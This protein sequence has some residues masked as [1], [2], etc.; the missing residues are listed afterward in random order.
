MEQQKYDFD[1]VVRGCITI[2][3]LVGLYFV[4][5]RLSGVLVPF[6][7][8]WLIAYMLNPLCEFYQYKCRMKVRGLAVAAT[9][10]TAL[11]A[12]A[13]FVLM[14]IP[15]M[16]NEMHHLSDYLS[17]YLTDFRFSDYVPEEMQKRLRDA[18]VD[19]DLI[20]LVQSDGFLSVLQTSAPKLWA[21]LSGGVSA[22]SGL[23]VSFICV[24]YIIFI[25]LD[26]DV[27]AD[28]WV[29]MIPK[30]YRAHAEMLMT[31]LSGGMNSYFRGQ[32]KVASIV[33]ILFAIGFEIIGLPLG[34]VMGL[35]IGVLNMV[36]YLQTLA[37][38]PC[39]LLGV[40]QSAETGRPFWVIFLCLLVVF[41]LV[42]ATQ[43]LVLTPRIMGKAMGLH[44]A[45]ILLALS[46]WGSLLGVA[47]MII[48]LPMTTLMISYYRRFVIDK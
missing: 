16:V 12:V 47:G 25:L 10:I 48:A 3:V 26:Y 32:A 15:P 28:A 43:D 46:V 39:L 22:I 35:L 42:Q 8:S 30:K 44:P 7:V 5:R 45:I 14:V 13:V 29:R 27:L 33:G 18:I 21:V 40:L 36:P 38:F 41:V 37:V 23:A 4:V 24:L 9:I 2:A 34:I 1:R 31:D 17:H 20:S 6:L 11:L 19:A